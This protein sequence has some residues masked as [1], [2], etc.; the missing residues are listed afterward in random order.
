MIS[1]RLSDDEYA[2]LRNLCEAEGARSVSDVARD[3]VQRLICQT[4]P[5]NVDAALRD[6]TGRIES[7]DLRLRLL[8]VTTAGRSDGQA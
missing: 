6:L 4:A 7:I 5:A 1:F 3:A 2:N 8:E